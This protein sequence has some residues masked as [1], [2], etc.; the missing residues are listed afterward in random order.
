MIYRKRL[1]R[2]QIVIPT[3]LILIAA[4]LL[5]FSFLASDA[6]EGNIPVHTSTDVTK[7]IATDTNATATDAVTETVLSTPT[8]AQTTESMTEKATE[9]ESETEPLTELPTEP[10]T[11]PPTETETEPTTEQTTT[12][13]E[14]TTKQTTTRA[15]T[16]QQTTKETTKKQTTT[17]QTTTKQSTTKQTTTKQATTKK[18]SYDFSVCS[19]T[20]LTKEASDALAAL[21]DYR[22]ENGLATFR[23]SDTLD[24]MAK[25]RA[26]E[27]SVDHFSGYY[28]PDGSAWYTIIEEAGLD[29]S[30]FG[31]NELIGVYTGNVAASYWYASP[32]QKDRILDSGFTYASVACY[33][34]DGTYYWI[35]LFW[36]P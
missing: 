27:Y 31:E 4:L 20:F 8:D 13:K 21:N 26:Y 33:S 28:R 3:I 16:K 34:I 29:Y 22:K 30:L 17:K 15:T 12:V 19:G 24:T 25:V 7:T 23:T 32:E 14:T 35:T 11:E 1:T 10:L 36:A 9:T 5:A 2:L 18:W 6:K